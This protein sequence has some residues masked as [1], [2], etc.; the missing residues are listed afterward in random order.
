MTAASRAWFSAC[1]CI[2]LVCSSAGL[3][4]PAYNA[5][6]HGNELWTS[7]HVTRIIVI[8][9]PEI[10]RS[11]ANNFITTTAL[12]FNISYKYFLMVQKQK[13]KRS[14]KTILSMYISTS[15]K[16]YCTII[17]M[18]EVENGNIDS[19]VFN[20]C[21]HSNLFFQFIQKCKGRRFEPNK[22]NK[23]L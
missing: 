17:D 4:I 11:R 3:E 21:W 18:T 2:V 16:S 9:P 19:S 20:R 13:K 6:H 1:S 5:V 7:S 8:M 10:L 23:C 15:K 14:L 22:R 12:F